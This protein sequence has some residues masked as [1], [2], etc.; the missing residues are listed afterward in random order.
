M[1]QTRWLSDFSCLSEYYRLYP[2]NLA[3]N[4]VCPCLSFYLFFV[5][6]PDFMTMCSVYIFYI[7]KKYADS[8]R[9]FDRDE[10]VAIDARHNQIIMTVCIFFYYLLYALLYEGKTQLANIK[11]FYY[12]WS[13]VTNATY[14]QKVHSHNKSLL[15]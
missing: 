12:V 15:L 14:I 13:S 9:Y 1:K 5:L 3:S 4:S 7:G 10:E 2:S 8:V 6:D 11:L